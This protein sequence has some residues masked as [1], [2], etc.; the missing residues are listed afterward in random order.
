MNFATSPSSTPEMYPPL[1][2]PTTS[3]WPWKR[4]TITASSLYLPSIN[5]YLQDHALQ[6]VAL[7]GPLVSRVRKGLANCHGDLAP[8]TQRLPLPAP[9]AFEILELAESLKVTVE[10]HW[11]DPD[12]PLLWAAVVTIT[13]YVFFSLGECGACALYMGR[14]RGGR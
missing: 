4:G 8:L 9:V 5:K 11:S 14:H 13:S 12:I 10:F 6:P 2:S 3:L 7:V 1:T